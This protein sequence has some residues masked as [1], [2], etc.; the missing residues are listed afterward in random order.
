L[1]SNGNLPGRLSRGSEGKTY[2]ENAGTTHDV[3]DNK[4]SFF[5][6]HDVHENKDT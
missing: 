6:P 1:V 4:G 3:V 2:S 5:G